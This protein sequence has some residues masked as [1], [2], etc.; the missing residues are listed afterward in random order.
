[1]KKTNALKGM[2]LCK[3][4]PPVSGYGK[5]ERLYLVRKH[6]TGSYERLI[7]D[8][9]LHRFF[10]NHWPMYARTDKTD[11]C[12]W[13]RLKVQEYDQALNE[14]STHQD[15]VWYCQSTIDSTLLKSDRLMVYVR[16]QIMDDTGWHARIYMD[17]SDAS[18]QFWAI[19]KRIASSRRRRVMN[20]FEIPYY[21]D[22]WA[23][24][25]VW[26][27]LRIYKGKKVGS[28]FFG[29][30]SLYIRNVVINE[31]KKEKMYARVMEVEGEVDMSDVERHIW[32]QQTVKACIM[33]M[34]RKDH[35]DRLCDWLRD[36]TSVPPAE[37]HKL[38]GIIRYALKQLPLDAHDV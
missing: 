21:D 28:H 38:V 7:T 19:A 17:A 3:M 12:R 33:R 10:L 22:N 18:M 6:K 20:K 23:E 36:Q 37:F 35:I 34:R 4:H 27:A 29:W 31:I 24:S 26:L 25:A 2:P 5:F 32:A 30:L 15:I 13:L 16:P 14:K 11:V 1:M 8:E 9:E